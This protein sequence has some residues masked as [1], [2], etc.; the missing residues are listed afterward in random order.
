MA[1]EFVN[2]SYVFNPSLK[3]IDLSSIPNFDIKLL[4][5]ITNLTIGNTHI[6][7]AGAETG[8][9]YSSLAGNVITLQYDT[10]SMN[11]TDELL[12][13]Y[14][15]PSTLKLINFEGEAVEVKATENGALAIG[16]EVQKFADNF[17][18]ITPDINKWDFAFTNQGGTL[19]TKGGNSTGAS[20]LRISMC[21]FTP[22]SEYRLLS[23]RSFKLPNRF[24]FAYSA[25]Q[26]VSTQELE[27]SLVGVDENGVVETYNPNKPDMP[28]LGN[29]SVTSNTA[30]INFSSPHPFKGGDRVI[31][32]NN[33]DTRMNTGPALVTVVNLLQIT[34]PLTSTISNGTYVGEGIVKYQD[35]ST[36]SSNVAGLLLESGTATAG[37]I[38]CN[39]NGQSPRM[40]SSTITTSVA[41]QINTSPYTD[42]FVSPNL[43]EITLSMQELLYH[44]RVP[45]GLTAPSGATRISQNLPDEEKL[46][47]IRFRAKNL[48]RLTRPVAKIVSISKT[49]TTT[50]T[51]IT[52]VPHNL[53]STSNITITGVRD[54]T[55]FPNTGIASGGIT[56]INSTTFSCIVGTASTSSSAGGS[57]ILLNNAISLLGV[58]TL[59]VQSISR[60][61]NVMTITV[62]TT[63]TGALPGEYW[64]LH[65]CDATSMGFYDGTYLIL[66]MTGSTYEAIYIPNPNPNLGD[67]ATI[68]CGGTFFKR[69]DFRLH[70]IQELEYTR[71]VVE[72]YNQNG[73]T[74]LSKALPTNIVNTVPVNVSNT[75][76]PTTLTGGT[77]NIATLNTLTAGNIAPPTLNADETSVAVTT[78]TST[79]ARTPANGNVMSYSIGITAVSGTNPEYYAEILGTIDGTNFIRVGS[80]SRISQIGIYTTPFLP[81]GTFRQFRVD[82]T[83]SGTSPSFT[84]TINRISAND[85][86]L[87]GQEYE[88]LPSQFLL[89]TAGNT[90]NVIYNLNHNKWELTGL[91]TGGY[92]NNVRITLQGANGTPRNTTT[93][94]FNELVWLDIDNAI[95]LQLLN[96]TAG[97]AS[98]TN[99]NSQ[100]LRLIVINPQA[101]A[102]VGRLIMR[103]TN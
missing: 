72:L 94:G 42:A 5:N 99:V 17:T 86:K 49:G 35:P 4:A 26:R 59:S 2:Y 90:S 100:W 3:T 30:T 79:T 71:N 13:Q 93:A 33:L 57:V 25:S 92:N 20:Y 67:F 74:D 32:V 12:I 39:A 37:T 23:K 10:T 19:V 48:A 70:F 77:N 46:Y 6:Y 83:L 15:I 54:I 69:T 87:T 51:I 22:E 56:I 45:D 78:N 40:V 68:N 55:N 82:Q 1:K 81:I 27:I 98:F 29:I 38:F 85:T 95:G 96:N 103:G 60:T 89:T 41:N 84:R 66:R 102:V 91:F 14:N 11:S 18:T 61:N 64:E 75:S 28:I 73:V 62:N 36:L 43:N 31:L 24:N 8:L 16:N 101:G 7:V 47:K 44:S 58:T 80:L 53:T 9:G 50:A 63:A 34:I 21:P 88:I 65:G 76:I 97:K 52:N